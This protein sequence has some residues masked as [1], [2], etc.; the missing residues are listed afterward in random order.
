MSETPEERKAV[1]AVSSVLRNGPDQVIID[2]DG[3]TK[4][5]PKSWRM[6]SS[7]RLAIVYIRD[8]GWTLG[9]SREQGAV[10]EAM[11][12]GDWIGRLDRTT[13]IKTGMIVFALT[14]FS[15]QGFEYEACTFKEDGTFSGGRESAE[16][17][18]SRIEPNPS[19]MSLEALRD[20]LKKGV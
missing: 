3:G 18:T 15:Q 20:K 8:D 5:V 10:A 4:D 6:A 1:I 2:I 14:V 11:W 12:K 17:D 7:T 13:N 9:C 16:M 19:G